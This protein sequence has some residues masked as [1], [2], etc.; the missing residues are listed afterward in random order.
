MPVPESETLRSSDPP[1]DRAPLSLL[2]NPREE[3]KGELQE[4][5]D[6]EEDES[7]HHCGAIE[8]FQYFYLPDTGTFSH[9]TCNECGGPS[10]S[11]T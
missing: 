3:D 6:E 11:A 1:L 5:E 4:E 7:C 8:S 10:M 2:P 9:S